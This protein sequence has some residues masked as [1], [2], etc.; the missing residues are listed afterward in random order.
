MNE[1]YTTIGDHT[2]KLI[3]PPKYLMA[4]LKSDFPAKHTT[5]DL[6]ITIHEEYGIPFSG[7]EVHITNNENKITFERADYLIEVNSNYTEAT[8]SVHD[9][10]ALK[11]AL[12]NVYSSF[13]AHHNWGLLIHSSC[14]IENGASSYFCRSVRS[15]EVNRC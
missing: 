4:M 1:L 13:I 15:G 12:M 7:Y 10:L 14:I 6:S 9:D 3:N 11:H 2:I 8:I 5:P